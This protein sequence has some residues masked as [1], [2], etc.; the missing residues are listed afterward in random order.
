MTKL[1]KLRTAMLQQNIPAI[2]VSSEVNQRYLTAFAFTDGYVLV[3]HTPG[4]GICR[5][6]CVIIL[7]MYVS[8]ALV[9][10]SVA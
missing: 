7:S 3:T 4:A 10:N 6:M 9:I 1:Q 8:F 2:L 5:I